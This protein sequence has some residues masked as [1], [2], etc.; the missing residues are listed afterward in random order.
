MEG[1]GAGSVV[2]FI[3][4]TAPA[5]DAAPG[6]RQPQRECEGG[7]GLL[8]RAA[9]AA[10]D[11]VR[12]AGEVIQGARAEAACQRIEREQRL[13]WEA[14]RGRAWAVEEVM[15][16]EEAEATASGS[17][18]RA[19]RTT[20]SD[21]AFVAGRAATAAK[22]QL[23]S[24]ARELNL[25]QPPPPDVFEDEEY[26]DDEWGHSRS[27]ML[28]PPIARPAGRTRY[29]APPTPVDREQQPPPPPPPPQPG[30][31]AEVAA[32]RGVEDLVRD[33]PVVYDCVASTRCPHHCTSISQHM[34]TLS[35]Q[36]CSSAA[37]TPADIDA[38]LC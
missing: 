29:H 5:S 14:G 10:R 24:A 32:R 26:D 35:R 3:N 2:D 25:V 36:R 8:S 18:W 23:A 34:Q 13:Q 1:A 21:A 22:G 4:A 11:K 33:G 9:H 28:P 17:A 38:L 15:Q 30:P 6:Q 16:R 31:Q 19:I 27:R 7:A 20:A 12:D 37:P